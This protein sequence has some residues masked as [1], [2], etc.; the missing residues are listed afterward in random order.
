MPVIV[1]GHNLIGKMPSISLSDPEDEAKLVRILARHLLQRRQ[2]G[3]VVFDKGAES[4]SAPRLKGPNL[5]VIFAPPGGSADAIIMDMIKRDPNPKGLTIVSSDNEIRRCARSRRARLV[6]AEDYVKQLE[7]QP[8]QRSVG[9][10]R[11]AE[12]SDI[13]VEEWLEYFDRGRT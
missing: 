7:S 10:A 11:D 12:C 2:R 4:D 3:I 13:D 1:D 8:P 5:R 6:S 9:A